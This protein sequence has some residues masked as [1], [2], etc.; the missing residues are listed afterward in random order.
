MRVCVGFSICLDGGECQ[1]GA[2]RRRAARQRAYNAA[3]DKPHASRR[4]VRRTAWWVAFAALAG[5]LLAD[6]T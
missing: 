3:M 2:R 1:S 5:F 4:H 6:L